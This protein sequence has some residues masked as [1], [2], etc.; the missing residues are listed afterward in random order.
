MNE[1][2]NVDRFGHQL[3]YQLILPLWLM[4]KCFLFLER[5]TLRGL[6]VNNLGITTRY[7]EN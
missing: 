2:G 1:Y 7:T 4:K 6:N 5:A 3:I